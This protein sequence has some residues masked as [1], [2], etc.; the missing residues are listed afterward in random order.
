MAERIDEP[1]IEVE[2]TLD[3]ANPAAVALALR[4]ATRGQGGKAVDAKAEA[5]LDEQTRLVRLQT[6]HLHEQREL[7][8]AHLKVRRW[9]D[10]MSLALQVLG[11]AV[12]AAVV[13]GLG[14]M[15]WQA[16]E[17]H[18]LV[19]EAFSV[20]PD[21]AA[22]GLTGEVIASQMLDKLSA[23]QSETDSARPA[24]SYQNNWGD[25]LKV[26]IPE[27]GV[28]IGELD[29]WLHRRLSHQT[30]VTGEV[31]ETASGLSVTARADD[32]GD[33]F[34]GGPTDL[35]HLLQQSAEA[36]YRRT[37][38]YRYAVY[39]RAGG[40]GDESNVLLA[41]LAAGPPGDDR[42]WANSMLSEMLLARGDV[43]GGLTRILDAVRTSPEDPHGWAGLADDLGALGHDEGYL[44]A[45]RRMLVM[46]KRHPEAVTETAR[47]MFTA[48]VAAVVAE[49]QGDFLTGVQDETRATNLPDY[50]GNVAGAR[51]SLIIDFA[52]LHDPAGSD[53]AR[54][55]ARSAGLSGPALLSATLV[56]DF[57]LARWSDAAR[58]GQALQ[59]AAPKAHDSY[60]GAT[61]QY[62]RRVPLAQLAFAKAMLGDVA[63]ARATIGPTPLDCYQCVDLRGGIAAAAHDWPMADRWFADAV[64]QGPSLPFA[65]SDWGKMLLAKG[66]TAGAIAKLT[67][68]RQNGPHFADPAELWGEALL[69]QRNFAGAAVKFAEADK[70]AP[71]W[72]RNHLKW[73][74]ALLLSGRYAEARKQFETADGLGLSARERAALNVFLAR[75]AKGPLHG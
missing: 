6:E 21:Q 56:A 67:L 51:A 39:L 54:G 42:N 20:P 63:G 62:A 1:E 26:E 17:D 66:D 48:F 44:R 68:A 72:G 52:S 71:N 60:P 3:Q 43:A 34:A 41:Q 10:R 46:L 50:F 24:R 59:D 64:R 73:G 49:N 75:T 70:D 18:G 13:I 55:A 23:M 22:K 7:Q 29:H 5:F 74:E 8:L 57:A 16:H 38:P 65:Y 15:V 61:Q 33:S 37:Q 11:V 31:F 4:R 12:G 69:A 9:K 25:D 14:I 19:V 40:R 36:L 28:S 45:Q 30:R 32:G 35:D 27:T 53:A 2:E 47:N 58:E